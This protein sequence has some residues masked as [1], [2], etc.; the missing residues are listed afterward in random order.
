MENDELIY[1]QEDKIPED[2]LC[3]ICCR[4][5][6]DP[7]EHLPIVSN[8][9][10]CSQIYCRKCVESLSQC[11]H[12]RY[13]IKWKSVENSAISQKFLFKPLSELL[14][15]CPQCC[16][17]TERGQLK[18]H[19]C[20]CPR[21]GPN[22]CGIKLAPN[23]QSKHDETCPK[24]VALVSSPPLFSQESSG[25]YFFIYSEHNG[26]VLDVEGGSSKQG[27]KLIV[28][29]FHGGLNQRFRFDNMGF[30]TSVISGLVL[31]VEG[32]P[33]KGKNIIQ[34]QAHGNANQKWK[35]T[36]HG[37]IT[38]EGK[39][40]VLDIRGASKKQGAEICAWPAHGNSNQ[41]WRLVTH[42]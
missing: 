21:D 35:L 7:V 1:V 22:G 30:I 14:V 12:C 38:L 32:G 13:E 31:D 4:A 28:W 10:S 5:L 26:M 3:S 20:L 25:H 37:T 41:R 16:S 11:P 17:P 19:L 18:V 8:S 27:A 40:L 42:M 34:W 36:K 15:I 2:L 39:D 9:G 23:Q 24:K 33:I 6:I 29:P